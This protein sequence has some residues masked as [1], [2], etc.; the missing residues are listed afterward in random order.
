[1]TC[2]VLL[3]DG[4]DKKVALKEV[5]RL[6]PALKLLIDANHDTINDSAIQVCCRPLSTISSLV[7]CMNAVLGFG[8]HV[9]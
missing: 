7:T 6:H 5:C 3:V 4:N 2:N 9:H 1:M 8:E